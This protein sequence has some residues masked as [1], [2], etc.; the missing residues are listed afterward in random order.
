MDTFLELLFHK[1][2]NWF[3]YISA[4]ILLITIGAAAWWIVV[5]AKRFSKS[6]GAETKLYQLQEKLHS[7]DSESKHTERISL[8][9]L[10]VIDNSRQ[11]INSITNGKSSENPHLNIQRVIEGLAA[12]VKTKAGERNRSGFW[13]AI[14]DTKTLKLVNGSSGF[15]EHY[16]G[17]R[18]LHYNQSVAGRCYRK[19][20]L[21]YCK[22][23]H[24]DADYQPS[25]NNYTSL[26]CV[27]INDYGVL[28]IDGT[29]PFDDHV[30]SIAELYGVLI[31]LILED[32]STKTF[33]R[34]VV[35]SKINNGEEDEDE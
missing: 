7:L 9:L 27:P 8:K 30:K 34:E 28:T 1:M 22:N 6:L 25:G 21:I 3:F 16:I 19:K 17:K 24:D 13:M 35:A 14:P 29:E 15:P 18:K 32:F 33:A 10:T 5:G 31:E 11:F 26:I 4:V 2:P 23:V 20:E 12:D